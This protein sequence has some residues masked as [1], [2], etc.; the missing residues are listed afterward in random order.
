MQNKA[1]SNSAEA[2][3]LVS[4]VLWPAVSTRAVGRGRARHPDPG[5]PSQTVLLLSNHIEIPEVDHPQR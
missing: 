4:M 5:S 3:T 1:L 2:Q